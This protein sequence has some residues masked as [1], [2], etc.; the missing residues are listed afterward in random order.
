[1]LFS[2]VEIHKHF[3]GEYCLHIV[4]QT[5]HPKDSNLHTCHHKNLTL[6]CPKFQL[7]T[8]AATEAA[9]KA[10]VNKYATG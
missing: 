7:T 3:G 4:P 1:M 9:A 8:K 10:A 6:L 2:E 5:L